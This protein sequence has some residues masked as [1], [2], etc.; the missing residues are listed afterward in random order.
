MARSCPPTPVETNVEVVG[1][2]ED[3]R[4]ASVRDF[5]SCIGRMIGPRRVTTGFDWQPRFTA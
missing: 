3:V 4:A 5:V 1:A 2:F